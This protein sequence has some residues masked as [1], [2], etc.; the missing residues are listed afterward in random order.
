MQWTAVIEVRNGRWRWPLSR[1]WF[2]SL[3]HRCMQIALHEQRGEQF[4]ASKVLIIGT[5]SERQER[6]VHYQL[7]ELLYHEFE[8]ACNANPLSVDYSCRS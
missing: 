4:G 6:L 5:S 2:G 3:P 8:L 7:V 1:E